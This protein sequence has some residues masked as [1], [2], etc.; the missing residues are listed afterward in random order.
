MNDGENTPETPST[1]G[2]AAER[3]ARP[4][5]PVRAA[6]A[7]AP[8]ALRPPP[9][10]TVY[11]IFGSVLP[12]V[13][14][15]AVMGAMDVLLGMRP[16][17]VTQVLTACKNDDRLA[18]DYLRSLTAVD[19]EAQ[20]IEVVYHLY[21]FQHGH[22]VTLKC[23][24]PPENLSIPSVTTLWKS[25]DWLEREC[26]EMFGV[27]FSGHPNLEPLLMEEDTVHLHP[28]RKSHPLAEIEVK[29][30]ADVASG[31]EGDSDGE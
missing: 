16:S 14:F 11:D 29:Q 26:W 8:A 4:D 9:P 19:Q 5:R 25:A 20:G 2:G 1:E 27:D 15:Q 18:F 28:L 21:S 6:A 31:D 30:G 10:G 22:N 17:E 13:P 3:P 7:A 23:L 24:L 12:G